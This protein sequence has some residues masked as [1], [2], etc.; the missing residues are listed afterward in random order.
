LLIEAIDAAIPITVL[1]II[2]V[3]FDETWLSL[4]TVRVVAIEG[5]I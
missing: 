5:A 1:T 3:P 4:H 2:A